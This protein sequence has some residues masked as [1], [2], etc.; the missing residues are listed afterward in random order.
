MSLSIPKPSQ[1]NLFKPGYT[2]YEE[3]RHDHFPL[4]TQKEIPAQMIKHI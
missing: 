4:T 2:R 1:A 3:P